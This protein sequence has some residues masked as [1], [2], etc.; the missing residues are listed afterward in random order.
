MKHELVAEVVVIGPEGT[1]FSF[2]SKMDLTAKSHRAL[3]PKLKVQ[4]T[5]PG[6]IHNESGVEGHV[7]NCSNLPAVDK[8]NGFLCELHQARLFPMYGLGTEALRDLNWKGTAVE[9]IIFND[10]RQI[11]KDLAAGIVSRP[12][13]GAYRKGKS[14]EEVMNEL[15]HDISDEDYN[16]WDDS[17]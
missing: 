6:C 8:P 10:S 1:N 2:L 15:L 9:Q 7:Y 17:F 16:P 13:Y 12:R 11:I 3:K 5:N 14:D 4:P